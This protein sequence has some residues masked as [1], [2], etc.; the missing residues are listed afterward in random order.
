MDPPSMHA[1]LL[2]V[3]V[4]FTLHGTQFDVDP[5]C[6]EANLVSGQFSKLTAVNG[7][8][9]SSDKGNSVLPLHENGPSSA[10]EDVVV[11]HSLLSND[12]VVSSNPVASAI[13]S[14]SVSLTVLH[15]QQSRS[16]NEISI[17]PGSSAVV[18][19]NVSYVDIRSDLSLDL[20]TGQVSSF[21]RSET[22]LESSTTSG[23]IS[24]VCSTVPIQAV[25]VI[26][27]LVQ[28]VSTRGTFLV[29]SD[30]I[31]YSYG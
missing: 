23:L 26:D 14:D 1:K 11:P 21:S 10:K 27:S 18:S 3:N 19:V 25:S 13:F 20:S 16:V 9:D 31:Y 7:N 8:M 30:S 17:V 2:D 15:E 5:M 24:N 12:L 6:L 4:T 29:T 22:I 28:T